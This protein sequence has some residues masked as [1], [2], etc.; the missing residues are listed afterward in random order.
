MKIGKV[1]HQYEAWLAGFMPLLPSDLDLKHKRMSEAVF[2]FMRATYYRWAQTF[3]TVCASLASAPQVLAVGDLHV[4]NFGT[5]RDAEGRL[6]WGINDFDE[7]AVLPY[8]LDL[9]RLAVSARIAVA[10]CD[11]GVDGDDACHAIL[12]G[13]RDGL[14]VG[15]RPFVL[16]AEHRW[17][18]DE[19]HGEAADPTRFWK[20]MND[21]P[22]CTDAIPEMAQKALS[23]AMPEPGM[24]FRVAH[25][26]AGLGSL[27]RPRYV[28]IANWRGGLI[29]REAK[30]VAPPGSAFASGTTA[31]VS[32]IDIATHAVRVP[33]PFLRLSFGYVVRRLA[34]DCGRIELSALSSRRDAR[35]LL[36]AMGFETANVHLGTPAGTDA[37]RADLAAR[38][39]AW[40]RDAAQVMAKSVRSDFD[41]WK[42]RA[43]E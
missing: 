9:V 23:E 28:A 24:S 7:A 6:A 33:D 4:E 22:D 41:D 27:G 42:H 25:R 16:A 26:I 39:S 3:P 43:D 1:S 34:P 20:K 35:R 38:P 18:R 19:A 10:E 29:A 17:L 13:Y 11:L 30:A 2:P 5:W 12:D 14:S 37:V 21:L 31:N 40:L 36:E 32:C 8:T 15:G